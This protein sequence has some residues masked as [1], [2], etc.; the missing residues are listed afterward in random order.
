MR[1]LMHQISAHPALDLQ[2]IATGAHL[3]AAHG[4]TLS[5][6]E[7]QGVIVDETV[8]MLL[9]SDSPE[10]VGTSLGL[11]VIGLTRALGRLSPDIV[12]LLGDR[13]EALAAAQSAMVLGLPIA[14]IH[15]GEA[16]EGVIDEAIRHSI[17]KM[18][19]LHFVAAAPFRDRVIQL[20][21]EPARVHVVG[22]AGL[23]NIAALE[24]VDR[25]TLSADLGLPLGTPLLAVTYHPVTL[26]GAEGG[27]ASPLLEALDRHPQ[28]TIV[29]TGS[30]ADA[31]GGGIDAQ[32]AGFCA[33]NPKRAVQVASLG[34]R[35]YLSLLAE[36]DAVAGNSSSGLLEAPYMA[37][38]TVNIGPRQ[39]GR[40]RAPSVIDCDNA[41]GEIATAIETALSPAHK[42][43]AARRESPYGSPG[44]AE[45]IAA[46][47]A[48]AELNGLLFK[49]FHT[50]W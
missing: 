22:A 5:E 8:H 24:R 3:S 12:V 11:G 28:A 39:Q 19:H 15:G 49:R 23:D 45:K 31:H 13:Y 2:V 18:A 48:R 7:A 38:P 35:R 36:A 21:E 14:H 17:T 1:P 33:R 10:A 20:G 37:V 46:E 50:Q 32:I 30:N 29:F 43:V 27:D 6:I 25:A 41:A 9:A 47:I 34:F 4:G 44:A 42:A 40:P 16:T 26:E